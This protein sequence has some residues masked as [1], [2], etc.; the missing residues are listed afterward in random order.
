MH[1]NESKADRAVRSGKCC[2]IALTPPHRFPGRSRSHCCWW[3]RREVEEG[4]GSSDR[5][6]APGRCLP[7]PA[8]RSPRLPFERALH[9]LLGWPLLVDGGTVRFP[10]PHAPQIS[11][12]LGD[13]QKKP[14]EKI[15]ADRS[16]MVAS[17]FHSNIWR[18]CMN[19]FFFLHWR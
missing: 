9:T 14:R 17:K 18:G 3:L 5:S 13:Q 8:T 2:T 19:K 10:K 6:R 7:W 16:G 15:N 12:S 1:F 4:V 11:P